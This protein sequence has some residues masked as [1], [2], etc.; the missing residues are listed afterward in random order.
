MEFKLN[1]FSS[2]D[3]L[4][5]FSIDQQLLR[6]Q[7]K[8]TTRHCMLFMEEPSTTYKDTLQRN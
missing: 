2:P 3:Q 7:K 4:I 8:Q 6:P 5:Q 1:H